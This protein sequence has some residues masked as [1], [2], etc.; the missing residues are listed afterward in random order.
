M[1][2]HPLMDRRIISTP[3]HSSLAEANVLEA[4][5]E[6]EASTTGPS[7]S[8]PQSLPLDRPTASD[9]GITWW[10]PSTLGMGD[11]LIQAGWE[12][13][14]DLTR[15]S[16][17]LFD[18]IYAFNAPKREPR[19]ILEL[20]TRNNVTIQRFL[21]DMPAWMRSTG[22]IRRKDNGLVYLHLFTHLTSILT[23]R[24]FLTPPTQSVE[25][26]P[27][28]TSTEVSQTT[29]SS[30]IVRRYRTLAFRVARAS[31]LQIMSLVRH[32]PLSSPCVTLP[33]AVYSACTI[34]L[35]SPEDPAAMDGVR[36]GLTCLDSMDETGYW[37]D[38]AKDASDRIK[39]LA[40]RWS[41][42]V[43]PGKRVLGPLPPSGTIGPTEGASGSGEGSSR[44]QGAG[45]SGEGE[46]IQ[47]TQSSSSAAGETTIPSGSQSGQTSVVTTRPSTGVDTAVSST[48][49]Q[50]YTPPQPTSYQYAPPA[51]HHNPQGTHSHESAS[52][53]LYAPQTYTS[54]STAVPT[55]LHELGFQESNIDAAIAQALQD[56][57]SAQ[58]HVDPL[59]QQ[60]DRLHQENPILG[61]QARPD[62]QLY[63]QAPQQPQPSQSSVNL[64]K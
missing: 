62:P 4:S 3:R 42:V 12:A 31:A 15:M 53:Q 29:S 64:K 39:A 7:A 45:M 24:P 63:T 33:Y 56:F 21:D 10:N 13:L 32:T 40:R 1:G 37:V 8:T 27:S 43:G 55:Q 20:V 6:G 61:Q 52:G 36:T 5:K 17:M 16:D 48:G 2:M 54:S 49:S 50:T 57:G 41:V 35:L 26:R 28:D 58:S 9:V 25:H 59:T 34:L 51:G 22:A 47:R 60:Y 46:S 14:R 18:G 30:H 23:C 11:V 44:S 38:S 19:E